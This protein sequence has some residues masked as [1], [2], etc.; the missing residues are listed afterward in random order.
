M[1]DHDSTVTDHYKIEIQALIEA[2]E[3]RGIDSG[4]NP[5]GAAMAEV[6]R[7]RRELDGRLTELRKR[8][9]ALHARA[10]ALTA[11]GTALEAVLDGGLSAE[12]EIRAAAVGY[13]GEIIARVVAADA[14]ERHVLDWSEIADETLLM[15]ER[16]EPHIRG[17]KDT[18]PAWDP[19]SPQHAVIR[20][21]IAWRVS[22]G[23]FIADDPDRRGTPEDLALIEAVDE[24]PHIGETEVKP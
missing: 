23:A 14:R 7:L 13:A 12:Q 18:T 20:A 8:G 3:D 19:S 2:L 4:I 15:A 10:D 17:G 22:R 5:V 11:H 24:L 21:A 1:S 9:A 6:D 16:F